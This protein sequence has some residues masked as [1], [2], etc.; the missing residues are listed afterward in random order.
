[1]FDD[2]HKS[3]FENLANFRCQS[4]P[5]RC[6]NAEEKVV[7]ISMESRR[8]SSSHVVAGSGMKIV[9]VREGVH[10]CYVEAFVVV[11]TPEMEVETV[12][13]D[14]HRALGGY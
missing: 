5:V 2:S 7:G 1:M 6:P 13:F 14:A 3:P 8:M 11:N 9:L 4:C 10:F 12:G